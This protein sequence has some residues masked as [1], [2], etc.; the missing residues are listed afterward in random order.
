M[1]TALAALLPTEDDVAFY[2]EHGWFISDTVFS[3]ERLQDANFGIQRFYLGER[4]RILPIRRGYLDWKPEDGDVLRQNDYVSLQNDEINDLVGVPLLAAI[5]GTLARTT[6]IRLFH[7]Q[8]IYKPPTAEAA[9]TVGWHSDRAYWRTCTSTDMLTAW[10]PFAGTTLAGGTLMYLDGSHRWPRVD[11]LTTFSEQNHQSIEERYA[12]LGFPIVRVPV[13]LRPGQVGF[14][15]CKLIHGSLP[16]SAA[17][18]RIALAVH[19]QDAANR[20]TPATDDHGKPVVHVN[21]VLCRTDDGG[22]PDYG[23]PDICPTL[24][25]AEPQLEGRG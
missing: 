17:A 5:A 14:H 7:D 21:D 16:N 9:T 19:F 2:E 4:D 6:S 11:E 23:D 22:A 1:S 12:A 24:W 15:H 18:P 25:T 20:Y 8:L 10:I 13:E 3:E